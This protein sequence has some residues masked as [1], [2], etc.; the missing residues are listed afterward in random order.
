MEKFKKIRGS[1]GL[2]GTTIHAQALGEG[3]NGCADLVDGVNSCG[4]GT[5]GEAAAYS[6]ADFHFT[7]HPIVYQTSK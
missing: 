1:P 7:R 4:I 6:D 5:F 2:P 3:L